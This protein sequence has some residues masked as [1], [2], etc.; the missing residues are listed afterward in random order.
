MSDR[1]SRTVN[2]VGGPGDATV[3]AMSAPH[4]T[5]IKVRFTELD[6]YGH[7]NH[8]QYISY[9]EHGR[10]EARDGNEHVPSAQWN[11]D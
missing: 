2:L 4:V 8:A 5:A 6:P 10:T 7:V 9:F 3:R 11:P 1:W